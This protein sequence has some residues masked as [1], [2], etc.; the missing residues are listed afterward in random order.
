MSLH[1]AHTQYGDFYVDTAF[2]QKLGSA[3]M[4][5]VH[6]NSATIELAKQFVTPQSVVV[7]VG[8]HI[9]TFSVP[10]TKV[11]HMVVAFEPSKETYATLLQNAE[12]NGGRLDARNKAL[13]R[14]SG[15][16]AME[17]RSVGNA[18]ART[19]VEGSDVE[20]STLDQEVPSVDFIKIDVE[21]MEIEVLRGA[22][23]L[24]Q[25]S[26]PVVF[27]ELNLSATRDHGS[28]ASKLQN[29]FNSQKYALFLPIEKAGK[30]D[31]AKVKNLQL[32]TALIAPK[33]WL[34]KTGSAPFDIL[35]VP[36]ERATGVVA[37][38]RGYAAMYA[39]RNNLTLKLQRL[40]SVFKN[41]KA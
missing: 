38:H 37:H 29:F 28:S 14:A 5:G 41:N 24:I 9:G 39:I 13:G 19:L 18:G 17:E 4:R 26:R 21:G 10:M 7:D 27:F 15:R 31:L 34:F 35:A 8:S 36:S 40:S 20:V 3:L 25:K 12:A 6:P 2:D 22:T 33:A 16:S 1:K 23:S 11:A 32:I 30:Y